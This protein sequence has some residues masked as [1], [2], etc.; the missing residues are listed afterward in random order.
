MNPVENQLLTLAQVDGEF[1]FWNMNYET[2]HLHEKDMNIVDDYVAH[3]ARHNISVEK[4]FSE[5][6]DILQQYPQGHPEWGSPQ[7]PNS[8]YSQAC[9]ALAAG[10]EHR[11]SNLMCSNGHMHIASPE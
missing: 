4:W 11:S 6:T 2:R 7:D 9:R 3:L 1:I 10:L 8:E 5:M